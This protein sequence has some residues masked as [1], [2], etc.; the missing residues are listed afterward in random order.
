MIRT[1]EFPDAEE[2]QAGL[3][4]SVERTAYLDG[5]SI[6][7]DRLSLEPRSPSIEPIASLIVSY[8]E[9]TPHLQEHLH[10][11]S[12]RVDALRH[13][14]GTIG[15]EPVS[16]AVEAFYLQISMRDRLL[17]L[18]QFATEQRWGNVRLLDYNANAM[19]LAAFDRD[20]DRMSAAGFPPEAIKRTL[21]IDEIAISLN[22]LQLS[23]VIDLGSSISYPSK[24]RAVYLHTNSRGITFFLN[25]TTV[26]PG[27][28]KPE[29]IYF[30][31]RVPDP[32]TATRLPPN[33]AVVEDPRNGSLAVTNK[34]SKRR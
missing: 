24:D 7:D 9:A 3:G 1:L 28:G 2:L 17:D 31:S 18:F 34:N 33:R 13:N 23:D 11:C 12:E 4:N 26:T 19:I 20:F 30:F 6:I 29:R 21:G 22:A 32:E 16:T 14:I 8:R 25:T 5:L 10:Q 27:S 15:T